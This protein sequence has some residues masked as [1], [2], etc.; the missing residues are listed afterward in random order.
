[1]SF[2]LTNALAHFMYLMNSMFMLELDKSVVVF[3][4]DILVYSKSMEE[5]DEHLCIM[6]QWL[7]EHQLQQV[8]V[9][10]GWIAILSHVILSEE[11][12]VDPSKVRD[13]Y[14]GTAATE[15]CTSSS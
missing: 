9:L 12:I 11:I 2:G 5:H 10:V 8:W 6:L 13:V 4:D 1:M 15:V 14:I 3:V 7:E